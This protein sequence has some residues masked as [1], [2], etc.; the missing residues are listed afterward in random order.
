MEELR[1]ILTITVHKGSRSHETSQRVFKQIWNR[2]Q[3]ISALMRTA[4]SHPQPDNLYKC[5]IVSVAL[6]TAIFVQHVYRR[7][8]WLWNRFPALKLHYISPISFMLDWVITS[9]TA[10]KTTCEQTD[11]QQIQYC[12][13]KDS[14][15]WGTE[16]G[17]KPYERY[18]NSSI[19]NYK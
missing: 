14:K 18:P 7:V 8:I 5:W 16:W 1:S 13:H 19:L 6:Y 10:S 9:A 17:H 11:R 12:H 15:Q 3:V 4:Q 2:R